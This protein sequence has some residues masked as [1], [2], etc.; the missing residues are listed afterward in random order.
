MARTRTNR[1]QLNDQDDVVLYPCFG[2]LSDDG[3]DWRIDI[4]GTVYNAGTISRRRQILLHV[5]QRASRVR[6]TEEQRELFDRRI[7]AFVAPTERGKRLALRVGDQVYAIRRKTRRNGRFFGTVRIPVA[8]VQE[9]HGN[10]DSSEGWLDLEVVSPT[11]LAR[12]TA[13]QARLIAATGVSIISDIDDTLKIT[14]VHSR[15]HLLA[16][17][18]LHEFRAIDGMSDRFRMWHDEGAVFHYVSSSPW[19]LFDPLADMLLAER[20]PVG[21]FHLRSFNLREHMLR[22]LLLI[23]RRGKST[24][25]RSILRRFPNRQF[26]LIGDSGE[27]DPEI[28]GQVARKHPEQVCSIY[29]RQLPHSPLRDER[30]HRA[31]RGVRDWQIFS[32]AGEL[33]ESIVAATPSPLVSL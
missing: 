5:L 7:R 23:R 1:S 15:Q 30:L 21:S 3:A 29:I 19:Q 9:L 31:F 25:I 11:T 16:N 10:G 4:C 33:P 22:R 14:D 20:F 27:R 6:P 24:A 28:Y 18:F 32:H 12:K 2:Y 13:E 17:T 26:V 8:V